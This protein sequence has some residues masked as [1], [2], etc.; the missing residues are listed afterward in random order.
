M[1]GQLHDRGR[2]GQVFLLPSHDNNEMAKLNIKLVE[3]ARHNPL[4]TLDG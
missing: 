1:H 4:F 3:A 2:D